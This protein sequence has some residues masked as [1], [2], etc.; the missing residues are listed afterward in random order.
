MSPRT[1][2]GRGRQCG[3]SCDDF[4]ANPLIAP[5]LGLPAAPGPR[6]VHCARQPSRRCATLRCES[7]IPAECDGFLRTLAMG[8]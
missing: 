4:A 8:Q 3:G 7:R 5:G 2:G 1:P 6:A